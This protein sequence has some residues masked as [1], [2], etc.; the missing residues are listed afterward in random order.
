LDNV[1]H[2]IRSSAGDNQKDA[3]LPIVCDISKP[4]ECDRV[5]NE[6]LQRYGRVDILVNNAALPRKRSF[7][8][9]ILMPCSILVSL[10]IVVWLNER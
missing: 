7:W 6:A 8:Q 10:I 1:A 3:V 2:Q 4:A 9:K 5:V